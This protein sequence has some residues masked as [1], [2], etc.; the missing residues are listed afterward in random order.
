MPTPTAQKT[1]RSGELVNADGS[2]WDGISKPHS[3]TTRKPVTT[4]LADAI[5]FRTRTAKEPIMF[6]T[7]L[8]NEAGAKVETLTT[9]S[10]DKGARRSPEAM[11]RK[12]A[13]HTERGLP[14]DLPTQIAMMPTPRANDAEKRGNID[15]DNPRNG[16]PG[17]IQGLLPTP[18]ACD[19]DKSVRSDE[20]ARKEAETG[21]RLQPGFIELIMGFPLNWTSIEAPPEEKDMVYP[22][23]SVPWLEAAAE[24]CVRTED[25]TIDTGFGTVYRD[26][27]AARIKQLGNA[28]VPQVVFQIFQ[29]IEKVEEKL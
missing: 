8:G 13:R 25:P 12:Y 28:V 14:L 9:N 17:M 11:K 6:R 22:F 16:L 21:L 2:E 10:D 18:R 4:G 29:A 24:L 27:R 26:N 15:A 7:P 3:A 5:C 1:T 20:N 23:E 19:G